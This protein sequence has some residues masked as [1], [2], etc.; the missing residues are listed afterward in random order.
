MSYSLNEVE[1]TAKRAARGAGYS[2]GVAEEAG[3]AARWLCGH[4]LDGCGLL[5]F[6]LEQISDCSI[7]A[8]SP[9]SLKGVWVGASHRLCPLTA[10]VTLSDC[11]ARLDDDVVVMTD[12]MQP[13]LVIPF[14]D[15]VSRQIGSGVSVT[16][17]G[18]TAIVYSGALNLEGA[19]ETLYAPAAGRLRVQPY[20]A[21]HHPLPLAT[22]AIPET[23]HWDVLNRLAH[24]TYAP[25]TEASRALGAG[26]GLSDND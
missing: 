4:G 5:A 8:V 20:G 2:W 12:V 17:G 15:G 24:R 10:G 14:A 7:A 9:V 3:K 25:A 13:A 1:V 22:R 11:A 19:E 16:W 6:L 18:L 23:A 26:A 21:V